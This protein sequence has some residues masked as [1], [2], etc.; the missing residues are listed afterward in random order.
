MARFHVE[1]F[2]RTLRAEK[3][4]PGGQV[5]A[6][7]EHLRRVKVKGK[8]AKRQLISLATW[9]YREAQRA[10]QR[11]KQTLIVASAVKEQG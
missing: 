10:E 11:R 5:P 6:D 1:D 2:T 7:P 8:K 9:K 3:Y 4:Y